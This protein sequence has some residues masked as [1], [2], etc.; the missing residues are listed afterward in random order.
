M[1]LARPGSL[2][3]LVLLALA[4]IALPLVAGLVTAGVQLRQ[5]G[6]SGERIIAEGVAATRLTQDLY[7][8]TNFMWRRLRILLVIDS[9]ELNEAHAQEDARLAQT[10][11]SLSAYLREEPAR[12]ALRDFSALRN[13]VGE[14]IR[15]GGARIEDIDADVDR[16]L[17]AAEVVAART[18]DQ[19]DAATAQL[20][21]ST[22][23]T[24][25]VMSWSFLLLIPLSVLAV[26]LFSFKVVR[27][28]RQIDR[29]ISELGSGE[30]HRPIKVHGSRDIG[31]LGGQLEWL[32]M[33][34]LELAEERNRFLR[35]MSHEL[36]TP[37]ANIR[38][39]TE[40]LMDGAVGELQAGQRE[41]TGILR[42]NGLRLQR[43]IENLLSF[44]A[45][46]SNSGS[47]EISEFR[48]RPVVKQTIE[49]QQ[50]TL[51]S[52]RVRLDVSVED[53][54][55][56]ADRGKVRLILENLISNAIKYTPRGGTIHIRARGNGP[57]L[58]LEVAD[59]GPGIPPEERRHVFE[60]FYTGK[61]PA[62]HIKGTGIGLSVVM[63]FVNAHG[64][65]I[66]IVD[67]EWPGAHFR[68]HMPLR[69][70]R[71]AGK[72]EARRAAGTTAHAA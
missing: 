41:V 51:L 9:P 57:D 60:A 20:R 4:I 22:R 43:L 1:K 25:R 8:Q 42:E 34:L 61:P 30:L 32:R 40:L 67:G 44:S 2:S 52:Q 11:T 14:R 48:L 26:L 15:G 3:S 65:S 55:L 37:L 69:A 7:A 68:I 70:S 72:A 56:A 33:R 31:R 62:G 6:A 27:P 59:T 39:G 24:Q 36:K 29:A 50:L 58:V 17:R 71:A 38:E 5:L 19:I 35:H 10:E 49:N 66:E 18:N 64:G 46:Q 21:E 13:S 23:R 54:T 12:A 28:L 45:W 53:L 47:L 16:M 63:E